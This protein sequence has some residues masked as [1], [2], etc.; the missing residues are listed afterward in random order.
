MEAFGNLSNDMQNQKCLE[1]C[2]Y[3][4]DI[5][6]MQWEIPS[7][8]SFHP[9]HTHT[10]TRARAH[11]HTHTLYHHY[12][13]VARSRR[14]IVKLPNILFREKSTWKMSL[15]IV[16]LTIPNTKLAFLFSHNFIVSNIKNSYGP[17]D[18][19]FLCVKLIVWHMVSKDIPCII[20]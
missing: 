19:S 20:S 11:T 5:A 16:L 1:E 4:K 9:Q 14:L 6:A 12:H 3:I 7:E 13:H 2:F 15:F 10:H 8:H 17:Q 18:A